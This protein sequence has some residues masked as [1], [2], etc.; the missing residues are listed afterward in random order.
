V[1]VGWNLTLEAACTS[2]KNTSVTGWCH[3]MAESSQA[4]LTYVWPKIGPL[5]GAGRLGSAESPTATEGLERNFS[6]L[7]GVDAWYLLDAHGF[8]RAIG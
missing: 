6:M 1:S 5:C 3:G 4:F 7:A 2:A 8:M